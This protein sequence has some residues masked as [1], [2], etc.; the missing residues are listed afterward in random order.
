MSKDMDK[1]PFNVP[2]PAFLLL[3]KQFDPDVGYI[4]FSHTG[5]NAVFLSS[6]SSI[7]YRILFIYSF[8]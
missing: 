7:T 3:H 1:I 2:G 4:F 5:K 6:G 8:V